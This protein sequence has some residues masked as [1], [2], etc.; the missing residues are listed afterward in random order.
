MACW[1]ESRPQLTDSPGNPLIP[2]AGVVRTFSHKASEAEQAAR[3]AYEAP[4]DR[5][6]SDPT[7][8]DLFLDLQED[9]TGFY[10]L[11]DRSSPG[12]LLGFCCFGEEARVVGQ[13]EET[14]TLDLGGGLRPDLVSR[15]TATL[16]MPAVCRFAAERFDPERLR[17]VIAAFNERSIRLCR[18]ARFESIRAFTRPDGEP[19]IELVQPTGSPVRNRNPQTFDLADSLRWLLKA[20]NEGC[21]TLG[22]QISEPC[23]SLLDAMIA[24]FLDSGSDL[25]HSGGSR[26]TAGRWLPYSPEGGD[27]CEIP[28][29]SDRHN[30]ALRPPPVAGRGLG[31]DRDGSGKGQVTGV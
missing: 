30:L 8:P 17:V 23:P 25:R 28:D 10:A 11:V 14:G 7:H 13:Q 20:R 26:S 6:D 31:N 18:S 21:G 22:A 16:L 5:Y 12:A 3:W 29:L 4:F 24:P 15:G 9:G 2:P 1:G 19:F 27:V